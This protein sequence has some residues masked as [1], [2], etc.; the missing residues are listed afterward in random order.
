MGIHYNLYTG[1]GIERSLSVSR[2]VNSGKGAK[3]PLCG[4]L[5]L[6]LT[7]SSDEG[8]SI[9][10]SVSFSVRYENRRKSED[11]L[12][13]RLGCSFNSRAGMKNLSIDVTNATHGKID[14]LN[15]QGSEGIMS[16][17]FNLGTHSYTPEITMPMQNLSISAKFTWPGE[18][19]GAHPNYTLSGYYSGQELAQNSISN[20]AYGY[21]NSD[22][23]Q[24]RDDALLDF[25]RE[26]DG[27]FTENTPMLPSTNMTYDVYSVMG[28]GIGGSY[29]PFRNDIGYVFDP[30]TANTSDG[31]SFG[32][33]VG[34]GD[35]FHL[36]FDVTVNSTNSYSG[37]WTSENPASQKMLYS[38]NPSNNPLYERFFFKEANEKSVNVD[39]SLYNSWGGNQAVY[40]DLD[41]DP[42]FSVRTNN[43][44]VRD[45]NGKISVPNTNFKS[46]RDKRNQSILFLTRKEIESKY[47]IN[48]PHPGS[49]D[50]PDHHIAEISCLG[51][52]GQRYVYGIAA[53]NKRQEEVSFA[54][55][56]RLDGS[57][58]HPGDCRTGLVPYDADED[59]SNTSSDE[60]REGIDRF[61]S[62]TIMPPFAHSYLLTAVLSPDYVDA[63]T[64]K[65]PSDGDLG[66]WVKFCY[67]KTTDYKW[68]IPCN[69]D[70]ANFNEGLKSDPTDDKGSYVYGEKE[71]WYL[72]SIITKNHVAV[73]TTEDRKDGFGV[74]DKNGGR[75]TANPMKLLR[76]ISLYAR[77]DRKI[78]GANATPLKQVHFEYD[79]SLCRKVPNNSGVSEMVSSVNINYGGKLTLKKV[80]FTYQN[81]EKS[82]FSPYEFS[83]GTCN[84]DY[85]LKGYNRW[86][87]FKPDTGTGCG[88]V[89]NL[90]NGEFPYVLQDKVGEDTNSCAWSLDTIHLPSGGHIAVSYESDDYAYVQN[91]QA[92]QMFQVVQTMSSPSSSPG[93]IA[94]FGDTISL[95]ESGDKNRVL[96]FPLV[97]GYNNIDDYLNGIDTLYFRCL[98]KISPNPERYDYVSG[99]AMIKS[100]GIKTISSTEYGYVELTPVQLQDASFTDK[101]N[102]ITKAAIQ[103]ARL[104]LSR[105]VYS[106][107][108]IT[109]EE[110]VGSQIIHALI[111]NMTNYA[112][113]VTGPNA[114]IYDKFDCHKC[115]AGKSW[116]RLNNPDHHKLGGGCRVKK[117]LISD[118]WS[119]MTG[120]QMN[121]FD[122]GQE[123]DYNNPDGTSSGVASYEPQIGGDENPWHMPIFFEEKHLLAP[124]ESFYLEGPVCESMFPSPSVGYGRVTIQNLKRTNVNKHATGKVVHEFYT[125][126][127]YPTI[128]SRTDLYHTQQKTGKFSFLNIF[129]IKSKDYMTATQGFVIET[130][131]MHGKPKKQEV[132]QEDKT[133]PISSVSYYYKHDP[134]LDASRLRNDATVIRPDGSTATGDI[135]MFF[136]MVGDMRE[137]R[138]EYESTALELNN[139]DFFI[140]PIPLPFPFIWPNTVQDF[141]QF[142]S[143]TT[144]K[145]IERFG[146]LDST[147]ATDLGSKVATRN[148]AY[149][150][151]TGE[152]LLTQTKTDFNDDIYTLKY[153]AYWYYDQ[154]G[155]AYKTAGVTFPSLTFTGTGIVSVANARNYFSDGDEL[156]MLNSTPANNKYG[157]VVDVSPGTISVVDKEGN[158]ISGTYRVKVIRSGRRN[159]QTMPMASVTT[160]TNPLTTFSSNI[161][162]NVL[163]ASAIEYSDNWRSKC[164]CYGDPSNNTNA[165]TNPYILGTKGN[166]RPSKNFAYLSPRVLSNYDNN[167]NIRRD[168]VFTAYN[169]YYK[170]SSGIWGLDPK[171]WTF[172]TEI[173]EFN[174]FGGQIEER[175]ALGRYA[176]QTFGYN[177]TLVTANAS[178]SRYQEIGFDAF[179]DYDYSV[180]ADNHF[181]FPGVTLDTNQFHTG[182]T[183][184]KVTSGSPI[185]MHKD[186]I[187]CE[188]DTCDLDLERLPGTTVIA[189]SGG[190]PPYQVDVNTI[191][192]TPSPAFN[193]SFTQVVLDLVNPWTVEITVTDS[194]GCTITKNFTK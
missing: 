103:F 136:D 12:G 33:E 94:S 133:A 10:P 52:G 86:G 163:Q 131:D 164:D 39:P 110:G 26:K 139:D 186:I 25:N 96:I 151:E 9:D 161:F 146:I 191:S 79:Y 135:G 71:L 172:A 193:S 116:I 98:M 179:E 59:N 11:R 144:T 55:G 65:G 154:M 4:S 73:F 118:E 68:R 114:F 127:D 21:M 173:V 15:F 123:Y 137:S 142:R 147:V 61:Y 83:Y 35:V 44:L 178:N 132:Y 88:R 90:P 181:K 111:S 180:C 165:T 107:G 36:G 37:K 175:D 34:A 174:P 38:S 85:N 93:S 51:D 32:G 46:G 56:K 95:S 182:R 104:H 22:H 17:S 18:L 156:E 63:D 81:S 169:P 67:T 145:V 162:K 138:S 75:E 45:D 24:Y 2:N 74:I 159:M 126:K 117:L 194:K 62:N 78:N 7:S 3:G 120:A 16:S 121:S 20:P 101:Y 170:L 53:Y 124:D 89:F 158:P 23:G 190:V 30:Y 49:Y 140:G 48:Y 87:N 184:L 64:I 43:Y 157:W 183:S 177:Q 69:Q 105:L 150:S 42:K 129:N 77:P 149:D 84:P 6:T 70:T 76:T 57:G 8:L 102:P 41:K 171:N 40:F 99:Y 155:L 31:Y 19:D 192:G 166:W 152:V 29:R 119:G 130:N 176:S 92:M 148:L 125:A 112:Q 106:S 1:V 5:G 185:T 153:P 128:V 58:G 109:G 54:V 108:G 80:F 91:K 134:Y 50:A 13:L 115:V 60:N 141:T 27:T 160:L 122:Y 189:V 28:Q 167:T 66:T 188:K 47:G 100:K 14:G 143:A 168:G 72:D 82:R 97:P 187:S 113:L